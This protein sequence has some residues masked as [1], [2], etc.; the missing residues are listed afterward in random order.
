MDLLK[1]MKLPIIL[2]FTLFL[3]YMQKNFLS[4][5]LAMQLKEGEMTKYL[6]TDERNFRKARCRYVLF[7]CHAGLSLR[8]SVIV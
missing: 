5:H 1:E 4:Q 3:R 2:D 6:E 8:P 7:M